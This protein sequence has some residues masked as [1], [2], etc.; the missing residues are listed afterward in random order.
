[1]GQMSNIGPLFKKTAILDYCSLSWIISIIKQQ[2]NEKI[3]FNIRNFHFAH[4]VHHFDAKPLKH[5]KTKLRGSDT[6]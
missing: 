2:N 3:Y 6:M 5:L 1:M 4:H